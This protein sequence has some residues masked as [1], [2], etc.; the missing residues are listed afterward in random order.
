MIG[1]GSILKVAICDDEE[2]IGLNYKDEIEKI[3]K[4]YGIE[5]EIDVF[6]DGYSFLEKHVKKKYDL[7]FMD[8]D[9]PR[10]NGMEVASELKNGEDYPILVFVTNH[11]ALVYETFPY[12]PFDFI[13]KS[14]FYDEINK[15]LDRIINEIKINRET[16][17]FK[18][19]NIEVEISLNKI[20]YFEAEQNYLYIVTDKN[21][22]KI[23]E[24]L[25]NV[26]D[27]LENNGFIR[28]HKGFLINRGAI[29]GMDKEDVIVAGN[30]RLPIG[31][32][33]RESIRKEIMR[34]MV[35]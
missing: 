12:N 14:Y 24:T 26:Q 27:K 28:I 34:G 9:M 33:N 22:Y 21:K 10:L 8:I 18:N 1:W 16:F 3:L 32:S 5:Y 25:K 20:I 4:I 35:C 13:R 2:K 15:V 7:V 17:L 29:I 19:L 6:I 23:R 30:I 11:D 31:R